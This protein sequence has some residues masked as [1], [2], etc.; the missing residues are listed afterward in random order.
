MQ[1]SCVTIAIIKMQNISIIV[2]SFLVP[3]YREFLFHLQH[4]ATTDLHPVHFLSLVLQAFHQFYKPPITLLI[5]PLLLNE[6]RLMSAIITKQ[7]D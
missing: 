5:S 2:Q 3:L 6:L 1:I 7:P 4:Q